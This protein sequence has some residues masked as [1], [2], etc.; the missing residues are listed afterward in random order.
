MAG[1]QP[2]LCM[3]RSILGLHFPTHWAALDPY[4][5]Q[6]P[7]HSRA[8]ER[9]DRGPPDGCQEGLLREE[10]EAHPMGARRGC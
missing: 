3:N 4:N 6:S 1:A 7:G 10:T 2:H 5:L 9:G 8:A